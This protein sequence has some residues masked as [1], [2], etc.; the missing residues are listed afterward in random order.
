MTCKKIIDRHKRRP[1]DHFCAEWQCQA[2]K[3]FVDVDHLCYMRA[4]ECKE[5]KPR[6]IFFD[7][8]CTHNDGLCCAEGYAMNKNPEC[9][10]CNNILILV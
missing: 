9:V 1:E 6:Y 2:C 10:Q 8:E 3:Q 7:F 4:L 5:K